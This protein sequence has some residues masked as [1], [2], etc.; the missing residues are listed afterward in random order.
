MN[1]LLGLCISVATDEKSMSVSIKTFDP[2]L[3][4]GPGNNPHLYI[5]EGKKRWHK[6]FDGESP[7]YKFG[8]LHC[9]LMGPPR[10]FVTV[11]DPEEYAGSRLGEDELGELFNSTV[12][13]F[14]MEAVVRQMLSS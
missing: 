10:V 4:G 13:A 7:L 3:S 14:V 9:L 6:F 12:K 1:K 2:F 11:I 5:D 8:D